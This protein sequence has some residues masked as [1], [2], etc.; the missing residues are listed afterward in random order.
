MLIWAG[1]VLYFNGFPAGRVIDCTR[2][3][4]GTLAMALLIRSITR[5]SAE[6]RRSW[7]VSSSSISGFIRAMGKCRSA[8]AKPSLAGR[9]AGRYLR[10]L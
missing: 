5:K 8:A 4:P 10:S 2:P 1:I 6:L 3:M 7:S 9:S